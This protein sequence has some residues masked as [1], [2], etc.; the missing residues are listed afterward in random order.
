MRELLARGKINMSNKQ[1]IERQKKRT[2]FNNC[3]YTFALVKKDSAERTILCSQENNDEMDIQSISLIRT[4]E[5]TSD[6]WIYN[7]GFTYSGF[8]S[9]FSITKKFFSNLRL[10]DNN[11]VSNPYR[12][13][14]IVIVTCSK[15]S[16]KGYSCGQ[17]TSLGSEDD[18]LIIHQLIE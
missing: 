18:R 9:P 8:S 15:R 17:C 12:L 7:D 11:S 2:T 16:N 5:F 14:T 6:K 10:I 4:M 13:R 1:T 3:L